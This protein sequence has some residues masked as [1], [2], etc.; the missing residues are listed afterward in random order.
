MVTPLT[1]GRYGL[2]DD[3][4]GSSRQRE[5]PPDR[6]QHCLELEYEVYIHGGWSLIEDDINYNTNLERVYIYM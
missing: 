5:D 1:Y 3:D 4:E 2:G 6:E